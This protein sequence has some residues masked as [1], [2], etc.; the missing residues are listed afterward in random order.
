MKIIG[1]GNTGC[2]LAEMYQQKIN[3]DE[4]NLYLLS[5]AK[6]DTMNYKK[7]TNI[8]I[9][10][11]D[12]SGKN[13]NN[14][15]KIWKNNLDKLKQDLGHLI[16]EKIII[17]AAAGGGSGS[18]GLPIVTKELTKQKNKIIATTVLPYKKENVPPGSNALKNLNDLKQI[19]KMANVLIFSNE[20]L[21]K[22]NNGLMSQ[23]NEEIIKN[24]DIMINILNR[25][26]NDLYSPI[27]VDNAELESIIFPN[28]QTGFIGITDN[29]NFEEMKIP[30][31]EVGRLDSKITRHIAIY[32][33]LDP[34]LSKEKVDEYYDSFR[35]Y[36]E[37]FSRYKGARIIPGI[38][39]VKR[40]RM[41]EMKF[42][43]IANGL[44]IQSDFNKMKK[45]ATSR[46]EIFLSEAIQDDV[47]L[48]KD[49]DNLL[50]I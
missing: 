32:M 19:S 6:E 10:D 48:N 38:L 14:G 5:T 13:Y 27:T 28:K 50:D 37:K 25:Y 8:L 33:I 36:L 43:V 9:Y 46:A 40:Q 31:F 42:I 34:S 21:L 17:F 22:K 23:A 39:R 24:T 45:Y 16:D 49:E 1:I 30:K 35:L 44:N 41:N 18:S 4:K 11:S 47:D 3:I 29:V 12:G 26:N 2:K 15:K 7:H 20:K